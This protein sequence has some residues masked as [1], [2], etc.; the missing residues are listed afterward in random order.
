MTLQTSGKPAILRMSEKSLILQMPQSSM[1]LQMSET[2]MS[3]ET[4]KKR[5]C[6]KKLG[7]TPRRPSRSWESL[8]PFGKS[9]SHLFLVGT[10]H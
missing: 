3:L 4:S 9:C 2:P 6:L 7:W 5:D 1:T 8:S 10:W